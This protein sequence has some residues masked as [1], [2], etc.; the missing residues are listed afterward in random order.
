MKNL[1]RQLETMTRYQESL[2]KEKKLKREK[3][4]SIAWRCVE[5]GLI[6]AFQYCDICKANNQLIF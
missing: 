2:A 3:I 5:Q 1:Q 4:K 6:N